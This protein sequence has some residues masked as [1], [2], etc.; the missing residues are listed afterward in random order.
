MQLPL[1]ITFRGMD[2]SDAVEANVREHAEKL[3][4]FHD[5]IM[6]CRVMVEARHQHHQKGNLYHVRVDLTVP[7]GEVVVSRE[8]HQHKSHE[9]VYVAIRDAFDAAR[10]QLEDYTRQRRGD[11][12]SHETPAHGRVIELVPAEDYGKIE[13]VE[14]RE[15]YFHRNSVVEEGGFEKLAVGSEVRFVEEMGE[16]GPQAS[17]VHLVGKH[18]PVG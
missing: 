4:R 16:R 7:G 10:R 15:V 3:D 12:K 14:G 6:S 11:V 9:D 18:H 13:T 5:R 17:T 2:P 8:P 1:Q